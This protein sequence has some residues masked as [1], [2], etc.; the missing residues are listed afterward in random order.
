MWPWLG[1]GWPSGRRIKGCVPHPN[2][3]YTSLIMQKPQMSYKKLSCSLDTRSVDL[4]LPAGPV[5][6][7]CLFFWFIYV[8]LGSALVIIAITTIRALQAFCFIFENN[9][10]SMKEYSFFFF[11]FLLLQECGCIFMYT[12]IYMEKNGNGP[13][14]VAPSSAIY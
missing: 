6:C 3:T 12:A 1:S 2:L 7:Q 9:C 5:P 4:W 8:Y 10:M 13:H 11:F 14:T